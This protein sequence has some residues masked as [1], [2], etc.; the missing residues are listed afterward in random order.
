MWNYQTI[1]KRLKSLCLAKQ[2][3]IEIG[4]QLQYDHRCNTNTISYTYHTHIYIFTAEFAR[5][6][7]SRVASWQLVMFDTTCIY[8][9]EVTQSRFY[10][11]I[12]ASC[13]TRCCCYYH[14][15]STL[16]LF[17]LKNGFIH[18]ILDINIKQMCLVTL[19]VIQCDSPYL[20]VCLAASSDK[21]CIKG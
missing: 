12:I 20:K 13:V 9:I 19:H 8:L 1:A 7:T 10:C 2:R 21:Q 18:W 4:I 3:T 6:T 11:P 14:H 17:E 16:Q 15:S 5:P